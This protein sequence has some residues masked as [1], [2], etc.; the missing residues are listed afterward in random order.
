MFEMYP[1]AFDSLQEFV[2]EDSCVNGINFRG[3]DENG[4]LGHH[5]LSLHFYGFDL[6]N[7]RWLINLPLV[8]PNLPISMPHLRFALRDLDIFCSG[9]PFK[10]VAMPLPG[11][12]YRYV[13]REEAKMLLQEHLGDSHV[14]YHVYD[15]SG[16]HAPRW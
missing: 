7:D 14:I 10:T 3:Y 5:N 15:R 11:D 1:G 4:K 16:L 13:G 6:E 12:R 8:Q 2:L 9:R